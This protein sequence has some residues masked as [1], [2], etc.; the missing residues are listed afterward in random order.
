MQNKRYVFVDTLRGLA[1][2]NM[3]AYHAIWDLVYLCGMDWGWFR[4]QGAYVWQQA[5]C[6]TFIV[7][8]GFCQRLGRHRLRRG[9]MVFACGVVVSAVTAFLVPAGRVLFGVLTL[10]GSCMLLAAVLDGCLKR[11][12]PG[13]GMAVCGLLFVLTKAA[14]SG[15][16]GILDWPVWQLPAGWYANLA[17]A[18]LGFPPEGFFSADYFPLLPW[19]FLFFTGYFLFGVAEKFG[20][21]DRLAG[22]NI[23]PLSWLGRHA[24]AVYLVHQ[25]VLYGLLTWLF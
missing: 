19:V 17:T 20:G 22:G 5:I 11:C 12:L 18:F 13:L 15:Y 24:L 3:V 23:P 9:G 1:V 21:L 6:W 25:P 2:G 8:S 7:L 4:G 10:I 14:P 16:L